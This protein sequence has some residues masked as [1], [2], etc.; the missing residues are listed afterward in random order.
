MRK[1]LTLRKALVLLG[2][3]AVLALAGV[4]CAPG[5]QPTPTPEP[6]PTPTPPPTPTPTPVPAVATPTPTP[7]PVGEVPHEEGKV[8]FVGWMCD[9]T[10]PTQVVG[11]NLCPGMEDFLELINL[12]GGIYGHTFEWEE[13]EHGYEVP[14][15]VEAYERLREKGAIWIGAYGTPQTYAITPRTFKD[16]LPITTPGFGRADAADGTT[17]S[18]VFPV[19]ASYWSQAAA[20][21]HYI[22]TRMGGEDRLRGLKIA[23]LYYD[24]PFGREPLP[25]YERLAER[26]GF[27]LRTF[28]ATPPALEQSAQWTDI[29]RRFRADWVITQLAGG[30][31][32]VSIKEAARVGFPMDRVVAHVWCGAEQ[33]TR[34]AGPDIAKGYTAMEFAGVGRDFPI[35]REILEVVYGAGRGHTSEEVV[36]T[37]YYNRGVFIGGLVVAAFKKAHEQFGDPIDGEKMKWGFENITVQDLQELGLLG[38]A[39]PLELSPEDHEGGG[40]IQFYQWDGE[41]Y[42]PVT[43]WVRAYRDVVLELVRASAAQFREDNPELFQ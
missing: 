33:D 29:A 12:K 32:A 42:V 13:I 35:I 7:R 41:K 43:D 15:G 4:A 36:G 37:V 16:K 23:V 26:F 8:Y 14:R 6:T 9:K 22:A 24:N 2:F 21:I 39:P 25:V 17:F 30:S 28:A 27:T 34:I 18:Y 5:A 20:A 3:G 10:G 40:Y 31:C 19:A 38:L 11:I 1:R